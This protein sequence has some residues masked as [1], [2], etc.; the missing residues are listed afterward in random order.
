MKYKNK[1]VVL[2]ANTS[3]YL[4]N[5]RKSTITSLIS[6]GYQVHCI[7]IED[8]YSKR[9]IDL[10]AT[11]HNLPLTQYGTNPLK[12]INS[13]YSIWLLLAKIKPSTVFSFTSKCNI[14]FGIANK[15]VNFNFFPNIS[16][17]GQVFTTGGWKAAAS[18]SLY[19]TALSGAKKIIFQNE[20]DRK[21]FVDKKICNKIKTLRIYGSG[22]DLEKFTPK[23][24]NLDNT[25]K[26]KFVMVARLL[27]EKGVLYYLEAA[28]KITAEYKN[29]EFYL[30]GSPPD[31]KNYRIDNSVLTQYKEHITH[32]PHADNI[33]E[34]LKEM[35]CMIL[36]TYYNEGVPKSLLEGLATGLI[37]ITTEQPGCIECVN[38]N[39]DDKNG[40]IIQA[41][42]EEKLITSMKEILET[43]LSTLNKYSQNS[44][45]L[46]EKRFDDK[47]IISMYISLADNN[48]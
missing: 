8:K 40:L 10:G 48:S 16:G 15:L 45:K 7:A 22:V 11:F 13:I 38:I 23:I 31:I 6:N 37:I 20:V 19:K 47:S 28:K 18:L 29:S 21:Y 9:L 12:E 1:I 39:D 5:F 43:E 32:I 4:L 44:R 30:V 27:V 14:Y 24:I 2:T 35:H 33:S 34:I 46:A 26:I 3:W 25:D 36:P 17:L 41:K 42:S